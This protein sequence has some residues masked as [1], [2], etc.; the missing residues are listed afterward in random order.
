MTAIDT[1]KSLGFKEQKADEFQAL[2]DD[3]GLTTSDAD[4]IT[5]PHRVLAVLTKGDTT[6]LIEKNVSQDVASGVDSIT[7]HPAILILE[8]PRGRVA[9]S[10][11]DD[12]E[13][14][15]LIATLVAELAPKHAG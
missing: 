3:L 13:N 6:A 11:H 4:G 10:N 5:M 12:P 9:V 2:S 15:A 1:L 7:R 8:S 14:A